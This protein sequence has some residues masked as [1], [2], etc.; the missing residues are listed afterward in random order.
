MNITNKFNVGDTVFY[1]ENGQL[2]KGVIESIS[3]VQRVDSEV[4]YYTFNGNYSCY[5]ECYVFAT[6]EDATCYFLTEVN[7]N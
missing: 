5:K 2:H 7:E 3:I 6:I 4:V 1:I